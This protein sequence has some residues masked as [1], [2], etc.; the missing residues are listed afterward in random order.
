MKIIYIIS[1]HMAFPM[2]YTNI[3]YNI[4]NNLMLIEHNY[5]QLKCF[6][7]H[8][9]MIPVQCASPRDQSLYDRFCFFCIR[10]I[11]RAS[12]KQITSLHVSM[13]T[14]TTHSF[15]YTEYEMKQRSLV[16][17]GDTLGLIAITVIAWWWC[18]QGHCLI[19]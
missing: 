13:P 6:L 7:K 1:V 4:H 8:A 16:N 9:T 12:S 18:Y 5:S 17:T 2:S 11:Y 19:T 10:S 14:T 3:I 15:Y